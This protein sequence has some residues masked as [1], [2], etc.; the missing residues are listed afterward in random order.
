MSDD[1][2]CYCDPKLQIYG[3]IQSGCW[4]CFK[5]YANPTSINYRIG[6]PYSI[7]KKDEYVII[8]DQNDEIVCVREPPVEYLS[9]MDIFLDDYKHLCGYDD[10]FLYDCLAYMIQNNALSDKE[11]KL[12]TLLSKLEYVIGRNNTLSKT[13]VKNTLKLV[14][15]ALDNGWFH[16]CCDE[17]PHS[18]GSWFVY[19]ILKIMYAVDKHHLFDIFRE[20]VWKFVDYGEVFT[21]DHKKYM[22]INIKKMAMTE[23]Q[24]RQKME[25]YAEKYPEK[26]IVCIDF[27]ILILEGYFEK[28]ETYISE[29]YTQESMKAT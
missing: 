28:M 4:E 11:Y 19:L 6:V 9:V 16:P 27:P 14:I 29:Y 17:V 21:Q 23:K 20:L 8:K 12:Y 1:E 25:V 15:I 2:R 18:N 7:H 13:S 3:P 26:E 5:K 24:L 22:R 10:D